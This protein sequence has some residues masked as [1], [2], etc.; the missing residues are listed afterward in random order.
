MTK[1][2]CKV[3]D[4]KHKFLYGASY[5]DGETR[6]M[7]FIQ[8]T[9]DNTTDAYYFTID[10]VY[11]D[12]NGNIITENILNNATFIGTTSTKEE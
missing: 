6:A 7:D 3:T 9:N 5:E 11:Q 4:K 2:T 10:K 12:E 8:R 1:Y